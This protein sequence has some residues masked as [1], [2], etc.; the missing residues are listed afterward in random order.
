MID[1]RKEINARC[2]VTFQVDGA[3]PQTADLGK[4]IIG[5]V[6]DALRKITTQMEAKAD[7]QDDTNTQGYYIAIKDFEEA[8]GL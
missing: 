4:E 7:E 3:E 8:I 1:L 5:V 6:K 2:K